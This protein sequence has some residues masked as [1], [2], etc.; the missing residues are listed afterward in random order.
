MERERDAQL[1]PSE[2]GGSD[3]RY[4]K[5]VVGERDFIQQEEK[6]RAR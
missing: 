5:I 4:V 6:R 1:E 3:V 2:R